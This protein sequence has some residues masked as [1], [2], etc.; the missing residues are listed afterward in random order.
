MVTRPVIASIARTIRLKCRIVVILSSP[1]RQQSNGRIEPMACVV[2]PLC[3]FE[4]P[5]G[6]TEA[7]FIPGQFWRRY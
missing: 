2:S 6:T 1:D 3:A 5:N 4:H 7:M